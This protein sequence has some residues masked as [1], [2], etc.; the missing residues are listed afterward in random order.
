MKEVFPIIYTRE[1]D[2][3]VAKISLADITKH[4]YLFMCH[5]KARLLSDNEN[6]KNPGEVDDEYMCPIC[7]HLLWK[8]VECQNCQRFFCKRCIDRCLKEKPDI[9]PLCKRYQEKRCSPMFYTLT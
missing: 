1:Y 9:C 3:K 4:S 7:V 6:I 5:T 2:N 8:P